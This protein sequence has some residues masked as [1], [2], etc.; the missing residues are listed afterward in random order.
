VEH[1]VSV[2]E[3]AA[4]PTVVVP[5]ATTWPAFPTLWKGLLDE[6]WECL[7]ASG[8]HSGFPNVMLYLDDVPHVEVGVEIDDR[9][10]PLTERVVR[11]AL[12]AGRVAR[13]VHR[14]PYGELGWAHRAVLEWCAV[15]GHRPL[16]PRWE[17]YGPHRADPAQ[18]TTE[19]TYLLG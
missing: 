14:G 10:C 1:R 7:R 18:L 11:S 3:V 9:Q 4:R 8:V 5:A 6:V 17:V 13:T 16:G 12:P 15:Q 19:V 2:A